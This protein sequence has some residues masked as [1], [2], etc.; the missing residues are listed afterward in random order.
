[1]GDAV[2]ISIICIN[3]DPMPFV[4]ALKDLVA[5]IDVR[6][7]PDDGD[8][9][10]ISMVLCWQHPAGVLSDYPNLRCICSLGAGVDHL[11]ADK[12][13]PINVPVVRLVDSTLAMQMFEYV[14][15]AVVSHI[16]HFD[17]FAQQQGV[18]QWQQIQ[19]KPFDSVK[20]GVMGLGEL[21]GFVAQK[22]ASI[23]FS[24]V[25]WSRSKKSIAGIDCFAGEN[26]QG[27]FLSQCDVLVNLLPLTPSTADIL[28]EQLFL[29]LPK[30]AYVINVGRGGHLVDDDLIAA[31]DKGQLSGACL[32]VFRQEP[33]LHT[34]PFWLHPAIK[35]TPHCSS[36]TSSK[37]VAG[38]IVDNYQ[39]CYL[40]EP[41]DKKFKN[42]VDVNKGY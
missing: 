30:G 10:Q 14:L 22:L 41:A 34:H 3:K 21:G 40:D 33:L 23:G 9:S 8:K 7:W 25:G 15:A 16:R 26:Q 29:R 1:M 24:V 5:N 28:N 2:A 27:Y 17:T 13:L 6:I 42:V 35:V 19:A 4:V 11:L 39:R 31:I 37:S 32:D 38:Q 20:V 36:L 12:H 18:K